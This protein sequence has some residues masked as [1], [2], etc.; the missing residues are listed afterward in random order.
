MLRYQKLRAMKNSMNRL[1]DGDDLVALLFEEMPELQYF[2]FVKNQE[3]DDN[4]YFDNI[5]VTGINGHSYGWE[6]YEEDEEEGEEESSLPK[7]EGR[8]VEDLLGH[9]SD[10]YDFG[11]NEIEIKREDYVGRKKKTKLET[12]QKYFIAHLAGKK[13]PEKFFYDEPE[14]ALYHSLDH[15][16]FSKEAEFRI[17]AAK[18]RMH[19]A[20]EYSKV[21]GGRLS[22]EVENFYV[23]DADDEDKEYL[24]EYIEQRAA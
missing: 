8:M 4:N 19:Y 20:L 5:Q 24:R 9:I 11:E 12:M 1:V 3:Y 21:I 10:N 6:G 7:V 22:E 17:F 15:G 14:L 2:T 16:R 23:L 18:G 13:L